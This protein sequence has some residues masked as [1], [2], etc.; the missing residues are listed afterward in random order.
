MRRRSRKGGMGC[1]GFQ[2]RAGDRVMCEG[3][4]SYLGGYCM[5]VLRPV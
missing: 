5:C 3:Q 4:S 1:G 2:G